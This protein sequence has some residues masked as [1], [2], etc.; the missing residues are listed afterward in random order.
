[1]LFSKSRHVA[2]G[3]LRDLLLDIAQARDAESLLPHVVRSLAVDSDAVAFACIWLLESG[4]ACNGCGDSSSP[5]PLAPCLHMA[6]SAASVP[7]G[8]PLEESLRRLST[9]GLDVGRAFASSDPLVVEATALE[10]PAGVSEWARAHAPAGLWA[11]RLRHGDATLGV[12]GAFL[13]SA[14]DAADSDVLRVVA[15]Q[16]ATSL[17]AARVTRELQRL[18][19]GGGAH[20]AIAEL[21]STRSV[22]S[23]EDLRRFERQNLVAALEATKGR[24]YGRGGAAELLGLKPTTLASRLK[25]LGISMRP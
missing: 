12:L 4:D 2:I 9:T 23:E 25:K 19:N 14:L 3:P 11:Q 16:V 22:V 20:D 18:R 15:S 7:V 6:A 10:M 13:A 8:P 5:T 24:V 1:V 17:D 21:R